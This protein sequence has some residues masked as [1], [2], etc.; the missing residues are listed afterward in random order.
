MAN[1]KLKATGA[2]WGYGYNV[3]LS[4]IADQP[5]L[6]TD[7]IRDPSRC[8]TFADAA[9]V[10]VFQPPA[11]PSNPLLEEFYYISTNEPTTHFRHQLRAG[12]VFADGHVEPSRADSGS[13][14]S[15]LPRENVGRL[16]N[17][18]LSP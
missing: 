4:A 11:T 3:H 9:Q 2:A 15:R 7:S 6:P 12:A 10:N 18:L 8:A 1:F 16:P 13:I 17:Q 5:D 14:D